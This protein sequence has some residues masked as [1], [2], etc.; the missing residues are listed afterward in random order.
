MKKKLSAIGNSLGIV[1]EKPILDLLDIDRDTEPELTTDGQQVIDRY[2]GVRE[3]ATRSR[4]IP[5]SR[6]HVRRSTA[7]SSIPTCSP[8][9][10]RT[11]SISRRA[12]RSSTVTKRTGLAAA[13]CSS[14]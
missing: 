12:S 11:H 7:T 4:S 5:P 13:L 10:P 3:S 8:W 6:C 1:I 2:G 14:I 9:P